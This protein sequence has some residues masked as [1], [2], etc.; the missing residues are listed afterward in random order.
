MADR[1]LLRRGLQ[2][3]LPALK[4][5]EPGFT[6]DTERLFIGNPSGT[7]NVLVSGAGIGIDAGSDDGYVTFFTSS[8][9]I[10]GVPEFFWDNVNKQLGVG[11][12]FPTHTLTVDGYVVPA[13]DNV[14][15]LG[16]SD[17]RWKDGY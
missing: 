10:K 6:T 16:T 14:Y 12:L 1:I 15:N 7:G 11:T 17:L 8:T 5:G 13:V 2:T 9:S 3:D 4:S